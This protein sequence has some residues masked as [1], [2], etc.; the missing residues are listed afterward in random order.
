M[1]LAPGL[2][3]KIITTILSTAEQLFDGKKVK[4]NWVDNWGQSK[5]SL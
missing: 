3:S 4:D 2:K 5:I 1:C